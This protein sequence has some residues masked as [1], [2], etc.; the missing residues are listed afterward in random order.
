MVQ[1]SEINNEIDEEMKRAKKNWVPNEHSNNCMLC[2]KVFNPILRRKHHC[3]SCGKLV[4][5]ACSPDKLYVAGYKDQKVRV[6]KDCASV[7]QKR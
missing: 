2:E 1:D 5:S 6:C 4:C 7:R 3:R